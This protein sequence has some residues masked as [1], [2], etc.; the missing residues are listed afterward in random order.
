M[1]EATATVY[2]SLKESDSS[3]LLDYARG[4]AWQQALLHQ[5][6][7]QRRLNPE[8]SSS[9]AVL[10]LEHSPVYTLGRGAKEGHITFLASD[11]V[12]NEAE[13]HAL[14]RSNR[15][16]GSARLA[17]DQVKLDS[18]L[19]SSTSVVVDEL[20]SVHIQAIPVVAPNGVPIYR[21]DRGGE[22][23]Y[24]G[25]GQ[26]VVYPLL[27]LKN[28]ASLKPDLHWYLRQMEQVVIGTLQ[29]YGVDA[30]ERD[31]DNT[32]VWVEEKKVA[33]VG[34]SAT[35]WI[36]THGFALNVCPDLTYF[37]TSH[38][39]PCGIEG[40][41]V[42]SLHE[43][44]HGSSDEDLPTVQHVANTVLQQLES[45]MGIKVDADAVKR[46]Q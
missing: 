44:M 11:D 13:R 2:S 27:D 42:T 18:L 19:S 12:N 30:A 15:G 25:P 34:V 4:W 17:M 26:L 31:E 43:L 36:T 16:P 24:H 22:V 1:E 38:I 7:H 9:D 20:L 35:R 10:L 33:A 5:R 45:L 32:G 3:L 46:I 23:T 21:I 8:S 37:D 29:H 6:L 28:H 39:L 14:S 40:R 41:G